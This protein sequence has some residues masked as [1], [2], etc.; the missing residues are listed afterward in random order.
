MVSRQTGFWCFCRCGR[1]LARLEVGRG[2][3]SVVKIICKSCKT[4]NSLDLR[5]ISASCGRAP[6][7]GGVVRKERY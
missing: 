6:G 7:D 4:M 1:T 5:V 3:V 2:S